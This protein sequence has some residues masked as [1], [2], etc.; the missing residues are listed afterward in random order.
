MA[1]ASQVHM[2]IGSKKWNRLI[3]DG[4]KE[5]NVSL[6]QKKIEL[7][8]RHAIELLHWNQTIN[9]TAITDPA[10]IAVNHF[11]DSIAPATMIPLDASLL[12]VGSGGGFPGI[13]LKILMPSLSV[14]LIDSSRKKISFLKHV[15]RALGLHNIDAHHVRAEDIAKD[16]IATHTYDVIISRALSST[17]IF[18]RTALP[19]LAK[20]GIII[21]MKGKLSYKDMQSLHSSLKTI[22]NNFSLVLKKYRLPHLESERSLVVLRNIY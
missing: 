18:I 15:I 10:K 12:D 13:P 8:G 6:D 14:V 9:L 16:T 7:L 22:E 1:K 17:D 11:L 19:L 3:E 21:G 20:D 2:Q 4:A 5:L